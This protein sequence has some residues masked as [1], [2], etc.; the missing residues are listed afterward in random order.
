MKAGKSLVMVLVGLICW[1]VLPAQALQGDA[2]A[3][4][5]LILFTRKTCPYSDQQRVILRRF[6]REHGWEAREVDIDQVPAAKTA[7]QIT[8]TPTTVLALRGSSEWFPVS[9]GVESEQRI[10]SDL[11]RAF[12]LVKRE[13]EVNGSS[14]ESD[15]DSGVYDP[16]GEQ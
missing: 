7:F 2:G 8:M 4:A 10:A 3:R 13:E 14:G 5:A 6:A 16:Q 12:V 9:V 15:N 1:A 11:Q